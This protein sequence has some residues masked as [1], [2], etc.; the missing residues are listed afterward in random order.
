MARHVVGRVDEIPSGGRKIVRLEGREIGIFNL[1]GS[2]Y[3]LRN[4]CPHQAARVC[5]GKL[6]GT[7]LPSAVYEFEYG[8]EGR[9]LRCPWHE[10]E[11]DIATGEAVFDPTVRIKTYPTEVS[12]GEVVVTIA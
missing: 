6:V 2:F 8:R 5:L 4:S 3:A 7:A 11:Y 12:D 10:W 1:G 9:I